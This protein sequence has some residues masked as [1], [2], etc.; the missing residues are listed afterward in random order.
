MLT[1]EGRNEDPSWAPDGRHVVFT[2]TRSGARQL[3]VVDVE[4]GRMRQ[5]TRARRRRAHRRLVAALTAAVA[6]AAV[7]HG[8]GVARLP[9][10]HMHSRTRLGDH[11]MTRLCTR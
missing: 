5:L 8:S 7:Q 1:S 11:D 9:L 10:S 6:A 3:W 2:S 4:S